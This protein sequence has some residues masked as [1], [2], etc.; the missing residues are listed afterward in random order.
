MWVSRSTK[1]L[2]LAQV[3]KKDIFLLSKKRISLL[4]IKTD[5]SKVNKW[6]LMMN[7]NQTTRPQMLLLIVLE[8]TNCRTFT[9]LIKQEA[10]S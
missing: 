10:H 5:V 6:N 9:W 4:N 3:L 8:K 2:T 1:T 7:F